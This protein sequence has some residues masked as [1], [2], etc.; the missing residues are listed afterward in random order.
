MRLTS[1]L[2]LATSVYLDS[3]VSGA[4]T[5]LTAALYEFDDIVLAAA[6]RGIRLFPVRGFGIGLVMLPLLHLS[7][8]AQS[9]PIQIVRNM[10]CHTMTYGSIANAVA[11]H[12]SRSEYLGIPLKDWSP[13]VAGAIISRIRECA[14]ELGQRNVNDAL[15]LLPQRLQLLVDAAAVPRSRSAPTTTEADFE[16][17]PS[18]TRDLTASDQ[19]FWD[20]AMGPGVRRTARPST[21][22]VL[23]PGS[24]DP[25]EQAARE[26]RRKR[27]AKQQACDDAAQAEA[28]EKARAKLAQ[29]RQEQIA[30]ADAS[31]AARLAKASPEVQAYVGK[32]PTIATNASG[33]P[34]AIKQNLIG[35]YSADIV[36]R[37]C[38][39]RYG[40][41]S[42]QVLRLQ[43]TIRLTE[44]TYQ[45]IHQMPAAEVAAIRDRLGVDSGQGQLI[46]Y[47]RSSRDLLRGCNEYVALYGLNPPLAR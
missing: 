37:V 40:S 45:Q 44:L 47:A 41:F 34:D 18:K 8:W 30:A 14:P 3:I 2:K 19:A 38:R 6:R 13:E 9:A 31:I 25:A 21:L 5:R 36:L 39:E 33:S 27:E 42:E 1:K 4:Q 29:Q 32:H 7:G 26:L 16:C 15:R 46:D 11:L 35:L 12:P 43:E 28:D 10:A 17:A 24:R 20:A 22:T 23:E